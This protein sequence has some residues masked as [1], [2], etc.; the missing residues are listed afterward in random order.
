MGKS[1]TFGVA[2]G[3]VTY[4][5]EADTTE[6][7][8]D[9]EQATNKIETESKK[10]EKSGT[11]ASGAIEKTFDSLIKK[12]GKLGEEFGK[13]VIQFLESSVNLAMDV[14]EIDGT[15]ETVFGSKGVK[16]LE[17]FTKRAATQFGLSEL[18]VKKYAASFGLIAK[19]ADVSE[20]GIEKFSESVIG[21]AADLAAFVPNGDVETMFNAIR[22]AFNGKPTSLK[23]MGIDLSASTMNQFAVGRGFKSFPGLSKEMQFSLMYA[24]LLEQ[25][26]QLGAVGA[27]ADSKGIKNATQ[28]LG[29][30]SEN[31]QI[32]TGKKLLPVV[33]PIVEYVAGELAESAEWISNAVDTILGAPPEITDSME[34]LQASQEKVQN[35]LQEQRKKLDEMAEKYAE[36]FGLESE[37][38]ESPF[39]NSFGEYMYQYL[40]GQQQQSSAGSAYR[41][42][43]DEAL[44][45]LQPFIEEINAAETEAAQLQEQIDFLSSL[46]AA[47]A[48]ESAEAVGDS[49][50]KGLEDSLPRVTAAVDSYIAE[51][52]R[53]N[54]LPGSNGVKILMPLATGMDYVPYNGIPATLHEGESVLT[55]EEAKVW[56]NFKYGG[57]STGNT[58]NYDAL[59]VTMRENVRAGGN[60]FLDGEI[61]GRVISSQQGDSYRAM[62]R[63][64]FQQ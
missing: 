21:L 16:T 2:D 23:N 63:S 43:I 55:A 53:L 48:E 62:E 59:G 35:S 18:Q 61:V 32:T 64:G 34:G 6:L 8:K 39:F 52:N 10:W 60:V 25:M 30:S 40:L 37:G 11:A 47:E 20:D 26:N 33:E 28:K 5:I 50:A 24:S 15:L 38:F 1:Y 42:R 56:R 57:I 31:L 46:P 36:Q 41:S 3:R 12:A 49:V 17:N 54:N 51:L 14:K 22:S 7:D 44:V 4:V 13:L 19:Q 45:N 9:L 29:A 27:F 58:V